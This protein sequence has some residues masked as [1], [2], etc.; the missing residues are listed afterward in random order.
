MS[1]AVQEGKSPEMA[2]ANG[3]VLDI[4]GGG[5]VPE[6]VIGALYAIGKELVDPPSPR[7]VFGKEPAG[8]LGYAYPSVNAAIVN[9][10]KI[11]EDAVA[12]AIE[13]DQGLS[14]KGTIWMLLLT[15]AAHEYHH[16]HLAA[17]DREAF[18]ADKDGA[19]E[20]A[21]EF[22]ENMVY[23]LT[24]HYDVEPPSAV[25]DMGWFAGKFM[26]LF[27]GEDKD[28]DYVRR[29]RAM[30]EDGLIYDRSDI[31]LKTFRE[32]V[33]ATM[34]PELKDEE[35][36]QG[37]IPITAVI[38]KE[39]GTEERVEAVEVEQLPTAE[40]VAA[41][42]TAAAAQD[43]TDPLLD[44]TE[45]DDIPDEEPGVDM[46]GEAGEVAYATEDAPEFLGEGLVDTPPAAVAAPAAAPVAQPS[47][48]VPAVPAAGPAPAQPAPQP[49]A[50]SDMV[51][52]PQHVQAA[53]TQMAQAATTVPQQP[54]MATPNP[55]PQINLD[56]ENIK[57]AMVAIY[58]A[59]YA[60][61]FNKCGWQI[62]SDQA[63]TQAGAVLNAID[64]SRIIEQ[65][66]VHGLID[67]YETFDANGASVVEKFQGHLRG[68]VGRKKG[69]PQ[70]TLYLN[71][72]GREAKRVIVPQ[73]PNTGSS[74]AQEARA[75]HA[76]AW[77][78]D[79]GEVVDPK[80]KWVGKLKD[81]NYEVCR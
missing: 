42:A 32:Y 54:T 5:A 46:T 66:N 63:F 72:N 6:K 3:V 18:E 39:D 79:G 52:L 36:E 44:T 29:E 70:Y 55:L 17:L 21:D 61:I 16:L 15:T 43:E 23:K 37:V 81:N 20:L 28:A 73:N 48:A 77:I 69:L 11:W 22:A 35:F 38:T 51:V 76:I 68:L 57:A 10:E 27:T 40:S 7:F 31:Q 53:N 65:Y 13:G 74:V 80:Q 60:N 75:G 58:K 1:H 62:N 59:C 49:E 4:V 30:L 34:D 2:A 25:N 67:R 71:L 19:D 33:R 50:S 45:S 8:L 9:L 14:I 24:K 26:D 64:V 41:E 47:S 56:P 78:I 12:M